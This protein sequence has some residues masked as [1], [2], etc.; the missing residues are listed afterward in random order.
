MK[1]YKWG[2]LILVLVLIVVLFSS[3]TRGSA[4]SAIVVDAVTAK[5]IVGIPIVRVVTL[6]GSDMGI[7]SKVVKA[8][9][10]VTNESG[11]FSF[12]SYTHFG[13][14]LHRYEDVLY[15]NSK[16]DTDYLSKTRNP[17]YAFDNLPI[18]RKYMAGGHSYSSISSIEAKWLEDVVKLAPIVKNINECKGN[19][20]C[21]TYNEERM[22]FC[23]ERD[24]DPECKIFLQVKSGL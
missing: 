16:P 7:R 19:Q 18:N 5:P 11:A 8:E 9:Y 2:A 12:G 1:K 20:V 21:I 24:D 10:T 13:F 23:Q 6:S 4:K 14:P 17:E 22:Q 15:V 3:I